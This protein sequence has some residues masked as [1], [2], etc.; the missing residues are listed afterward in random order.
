[1]FLV[2]SLLNQSINQS[3]AFIVSSTVIKIHRDN[4]I[5]RHK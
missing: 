3:T 2:V 5:A 1:L 4:D